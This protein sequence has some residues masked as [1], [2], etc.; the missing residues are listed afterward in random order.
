MHN[1]VVLIRSTGALF[2]QRFLQARTLLRNLG[3]EVQEVIWARDSEFEGLQNTAFQ[4][5]LKSKH[6]AGLRNLRSHL[7][8]GIFIR[9]SLSRIK[10]AYIYACDFD[11]LF[12]VYFCKPRHT[13][14][15]FDQ[16]DPLSSRFHSN[17]YF[18]AFLDFIECIFT[19]SVQVRATANKERISKLFRES[20]IEIPNVYE[21]ELSYV[22]SGLNA[23]Q[24]ATGVN[25]IFYGGVLMQDRGLEFVANAIKNNP[26]WVFH[27]YGIGTA[28]GAIKKLKYANTHLH[29]AVPHADLMTLGKH[30]QV[31]LAIYD[32]QRLHNKKT[33]SN[34]LYEACWLGLPIIASK[35][36]S[37]G[38]IVEQHGLGWTINYGNTSELLFALEEYE[39]LSA[40]GLRI[41]KSKLNIFYERSLEYKLLAIEEFREKIEKVIGFG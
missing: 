4:F 6:G 37:I 24:T 29:P 20:F 35:D 22:K 33:A 5:N 3:L 14:V 28:S 9:R 13:S 31:M 30:C 2:E 16:Y 36:T 38:E 12:W 25:S 21:Y 11:S 7:K 39:N 41:V 15:F 23:S 10:P 32:P 1:V 27:I 19:L 40:E 26:N 34:K 8:W 18:S 17:K